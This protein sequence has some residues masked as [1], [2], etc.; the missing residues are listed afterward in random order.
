MI[1]APLPKEIPI[2]LAV[3]EHYNASIYNLSANVCGKIT[4]GYIKKNGKV[5]YMW[6]KSSTFAAFLR[7]KP[8]EIKEPRHIKDVQ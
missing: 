3:F 5:L 4:G 8:I 7:E 2:N 6:K 1:T